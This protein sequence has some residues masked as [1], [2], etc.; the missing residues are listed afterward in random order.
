[1]IGTITLADDDGS[2][3]EVA[4][5]RGG[6]VLRYAR[7]TRRHGL[8]EVLHRPAVTAPDDPVPMAGSHVMFPIAGFS[9]GAARADHYSWQGVERPMPIHGFAM[10][11][12]WAVAE[13]TASSVRLVLEAAA[14]TRDAYPF[15][16]RLGLDHRLE[17]GAL[18]SVLSIDNLDDRPLPFSTGF[19]P[20]I[21]L[22]LADRGRRDRCV[23]RLPACREVFARPNGIETDARREP[24]I[25]LASHPAAPARHFAD[26]EVMRAE[27]ADEASGLCVSVDAALGSAFA[28]L[29]AWSPRID[30]PFYC[31]EP[32]TA[33]QDAFTY[34]DHGQLTVLPPGGVFVACMTLGLHEAV[35]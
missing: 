23:V 26:L 12:P 18:H 31:V 22:P 5:G 33:V 14:A 7:R 21:R 2:I 16:F 28:C 10:R 30:A 3:A 9:H 13:V 32:R 34:A 20:Y 24:R 25:L 11:L 8:V 15:D 27:I 4:P 29:T 35:S 19:H 1:L 17:G 6:W